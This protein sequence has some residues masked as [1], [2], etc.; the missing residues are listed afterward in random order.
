MILSQETYHI[1]FVSDKKSDNLVDPRAGCAQELTPRLGSI[2]GRQ[3]PSSPFSPTECT[4]ATLHLSK[5]FED[6][7]RLDV[8]DSYSPL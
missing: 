6:P 2:Q 5:S 1:A 7:H 4:S 8:D 3:P